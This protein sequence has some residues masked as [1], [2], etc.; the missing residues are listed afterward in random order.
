MRRQVAVCLAA[1]ALAVGFS[2]VAQE[3]QQQQGEF[4]EGEQ[5][6]QEPAT[7]GAGM[8]MDM[9]KMGPW[10]RK[11]TDEGKT[12]KEI[13]AFLKEEDALMKKRDFEGMLS[14]I[15]FP[16][17]MTTDD[18]KGMPK[19]ETVDRQKYS[20]MMRPMFEQMPADHQVT[21]KPAITVLSDSLAV[22]HD[23]FTMTT[24]GKKYSGKSSCLLVKREGQWRWKSMVE[25][26]WG[27]MHMATG[28]SGMPEEGVKQEQG[29]K[30]DIQYRQ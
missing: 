14:R 29:Q 12:K 13:Q 11:P 2:A 6:K 18:S 15:D 26:G 19:A 16:I 24:G 9:S 1:G 4:K 22:V 23:D 25:A 30:E 3:Q 7:G 28:G 5:F 20:E 21:H 10:T 8:Q 27:D 17:F